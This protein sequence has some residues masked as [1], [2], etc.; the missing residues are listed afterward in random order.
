MT[1]HAMGFIGILL[2]SF[3]GML[4]SAVGRNAASRRSADR[5]I[6]NTIEQACNA[7]PFHVPVRIDSVARIDP[8]AAFCRPPPSDGEDDGLSSIAGCPSLPAAS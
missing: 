3:S 4:S 1:N 8:N 6:S 2:F 7:A 5:S